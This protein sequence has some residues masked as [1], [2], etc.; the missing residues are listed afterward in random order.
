MQTTKEAAIIASKSF[1]QRLDE[2]L[3]EMKEHS[4]AVLIPNIGT[5]YAEDDKEA[6]AQHTLSV[7]DLE[8]AIMRQGM[9]MKAIGNPNPYPNSKDTTNAVVDPTSGGIKL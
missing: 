1:C 9:T 3:Q 4:K 6:V 8:S 7:R 2:I 5:D